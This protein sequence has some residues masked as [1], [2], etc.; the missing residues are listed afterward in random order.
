MIIG[1]IHHPECAGLSPVLL[2]AVILAV[3]ANPQKCDPGRYD[4][5][6]D[7]IYMNVMRLSTQPAQSKKAEL[8]EKFIDIQI[9][10]EGEEIIHYGVTGSTRKCDAWHKE[11]D[12]QL[13][14][15]IA[16]QQQ[17]VLE[18]GMFAI[19]FPGEPHKPCVQGTQSAEIKKTV[20]K[21]NHALLA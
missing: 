7:D 6:G 4:L 19:F 3:K 8:H 5:Q 11:D 20:V 16:G 14:A 1:N 9:L 17:V 10:L 21:V 2:Q 13:C 15:E 18:P 12:Y